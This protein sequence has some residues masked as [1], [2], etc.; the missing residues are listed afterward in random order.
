MT[1]LVEKQKK[2]LEP[3]LLKTVPSSNV[4]ILYL[5][6]VTFKNQL[7]NCP[8]QYQALNNCIR[9]VAIASDR[10]LKVLLN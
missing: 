9:L 7:L 2:G 6:S 10:K 8:S 4:A 5:N 3:V 1:I